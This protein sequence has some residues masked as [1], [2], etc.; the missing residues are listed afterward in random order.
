M[1]ALEKLE[2]HEEGVVDRKLEQER[3][4]QKR[5][6]KVQGK[7][8]QS[9]VTSRKEVTPLPQFFFFSFFLLVVYYCPKTTMSS[10]S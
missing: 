5:N 3:E 7:E 2:N 10:S 8:A 4:R 9:F 6:S 1:G